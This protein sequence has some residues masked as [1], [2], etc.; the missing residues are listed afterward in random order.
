MVL[1]SK[2]ISVCVVVYNGEKYLAEALDSILMQQLENP[3]EI[4]IGEDVSTDN[5]L[6][7]CKNYKNKYPDIIKLHINEENLGY[8]WN[9][10]R[11]LERCKGDYIAVLDSDDLWT[12][13]LKLKKQVDFLEQN[14]EY[15]LCFSKYFLCDEKSNL[16]EIKGFSGKYELNDVLTGKCPGT[17]TVVFRKEFLPTNLPTRFNEIAW[18]DH[19]LFALISKNGP[20]YGIDE[21]LAA[22]RTNSESIY[23]SKSMNV[24]SSKIIKSYMVM[25]SVFSEKDQMKAINEGINNERMRLERHYFFSFRLADLIVNS[26]KL[27]IYDIKN[28]KISFL[29][30]WV[31]IA[32][33][34][35]KL[36]VGR[37]SLQQARL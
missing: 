3:I 14:P 36:L 17:R 18:A 8:S 13:S 37:I 34:F 11:T 33:T 21:P 27:I 20:I 22:Y 35:L 23:A 5:T 26:F 24:R 31:I 7:I 19:I 10:Y 15:S 32:K 16:G 4:E 1:V 25:K 29:K 6:E 12:D 30:S 2:K 28:V 9:F